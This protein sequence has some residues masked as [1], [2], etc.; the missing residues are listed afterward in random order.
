MNLVDC[1]AGCRSWLMFRDRGFVIDMSEACLDCVV[2]VEVNSGEV[3]PL[4]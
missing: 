4:L 1:I 3:R 2:D